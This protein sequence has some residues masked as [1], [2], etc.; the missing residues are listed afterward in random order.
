[1]KHTWGTEI[2]SVA[3]VSSAHAHIPQLLSQQLV[4]GHTLPDQTIAR[5]ADRA[6][7]PSFCNNNRI[8]D[9]NALRR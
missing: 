9:V 5:F 4:N 7:A 3:D 2:L 1:M 6:G 8:V